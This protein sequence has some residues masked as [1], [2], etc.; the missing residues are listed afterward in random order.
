ME[1]T[2]KTL[3]KEECKLFAKVRWQDFSTALQWDEGHVRH[4]VLSLKEGQTHKSTVRQP[5]KHNI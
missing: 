1:S 5:S 4:S 2:R 3:Y